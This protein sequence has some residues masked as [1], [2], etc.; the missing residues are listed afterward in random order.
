MKNP[1]S[2]NDKLTML[3]VEH[4]GGKPHTNMTAELSAEIIEALARQIGTHIALQTHGDAKWMNHFLEGASAYMFEA[5]AEKQKA[6]QFLGDPKNWKM[7]ERGPDGKLR[8]IG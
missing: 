5:A 7:M 6:G 4:C 3:M 2:F 1:K 8:G